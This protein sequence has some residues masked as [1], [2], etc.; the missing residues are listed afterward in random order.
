MI[1]IRKRKFE[2]IKDGLPEVISAFMKK[3]LHAETVN[4]ELMIVY[5]VQ[6]TLDDWR[7]E[8]LLDK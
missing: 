1:E 7:S 2:N 4:Q 3:L 5:K 8:H 6:Y